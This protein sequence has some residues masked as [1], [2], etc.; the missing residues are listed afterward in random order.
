MGQQKI[1]NFQVFGCN[2]LSFYLEIIYILKTND[3]LVW[4]TLVL[5]MK[6]QNFL[7]KQPYLAFRS[8]KCAFQH[9]S[10]WRR[11]AGLDDHCLHCRETLKTE[12]YSRNGI[13]HLVLEAAGVCFQTQTSF[14]CK[15][16]GAVLLKPA[17]Q[18]VGVFL[19]APK[20]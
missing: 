14:G 3:I 20:S 16:L 7:K 1:K 5:H 12:I 18:Y 8:R 6:M 17:S 4:G 2:L 15:Y 9:L 13:S 19:S 10:F 11:S